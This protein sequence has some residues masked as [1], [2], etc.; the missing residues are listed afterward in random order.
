LPP[1]LRGTLSVYHANQLWRESLSAALESDEIEITVI[2]EPSE[3]TTPRSWIGIGLDDPLNLPWTPMYRER[4]FF[5]R[6][7]QS[8]QSF[9]WPP[10][11]RRRG[12]QPADIPFAVPAIPG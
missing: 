10:R 6:E 1:E 5:R 4:S 3:G 9:D 12:R 7:L 11:P 2:D 8:L